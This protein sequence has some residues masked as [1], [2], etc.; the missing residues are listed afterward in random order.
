MILLVQPFSMYSPSG[1]ARI[2]RSVLATAPEP[3]L[4]V[5]T[6][7]R[8]PVSR[9][10]QEV[11]LP[12][13]PSFG[14]VESTRFGGLLWSLAKP[15]SRRFRRRLAELCTSSGATTIH[16]IPHGLDFWEAYCVA[17][18]L[19]LRYVINVHD[20]LD[21]NLRGRPDLDE[22]KT[23]LGQTWLGADGRLVISPEMGEEY[24]RRYGPRPFVV[25]TDGLAAIPSEPRRRR[26]NRLRVYFMGLAHV[27][28]GR[29]SN[30]CLRPLRFWRGSGQI[31]GCHLLAVAVRFQSKFAIAV[32]RLKSCRWKMRTASSG[33]WTTWTCC[34]CRCHLNE[35]TSRSRAFSL[36]TKLVTYL[37]SGLP[38]LY[39]GPACAVAGRLLLKHGAA[40]IVDSPSPQAVADGLT[41][42]LTKFEVLA[43]NALKL[44]RDRFRIE[45][46]R[47]RFWREVLGTETK[48]SKMTQRHASPQ[49][50]TK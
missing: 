26:S 23:R 4:S 38:I 30:R 14:R 16:A 15:W 28:D 48:F 29:I 3:Y 40:A 10:G 42:S 41:T 17:R 6:S 44:G 5:C 39:H 1:G 25:V 49:F 21:Y 7:P 13:R 12:I 45:D 19:R 11:H 34:T 46:Q 8:S 36:S 31:C 33:I 32:Y 47:D 24:C 20:E 50:V 35:H 43:R 27:S 22:A 37:G 9:V 2:L 18:E